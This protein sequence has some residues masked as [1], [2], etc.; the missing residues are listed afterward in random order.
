MHDRHSGGHELAGEDSKKTSTA[1]EQERAAV[2]ELV[3]AA[4]AR[5]EDLTGPDGLLKTITKSVLESAL[6]EELTEHLGYDKHAVE[7]RNGGNSRNGTRTKTVLTDNAGP[8]RVEV[9]RDRDGTFTPV[10]VAKRQRRL[11]DVDAVV[12]SLYAKGLTTGE[13][14][15]HFAEVYGASVCKDTVSRITDRVLED[16]QA[17]TG[18]PLQPVYAAVFIDAIYVK[19]R[20]GQVGNQPFYAAIGV[21]LA[22]RRDV[23]GLWAGTGGGESAKFWM[24]VLTDLKNRGVRD[25]FFIVC[26]GLKGLPDSVNAVFPRRSCRRASST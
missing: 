12:L 22:G 8:V 16:M 18:R 11:S 25:V 2:R 21:D 14:S 26:D 7:G 15:A 1:A 13:I 6:E 9:P 3:R 4:R 5:G 17:W 23:L 24:G 20:D 19:V 10:I